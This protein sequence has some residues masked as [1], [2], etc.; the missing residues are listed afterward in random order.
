MFTHGKADR[1]LGII[2]LMILII[3]L[4]TAGDTVWLDGQER[5][6]PIK[7]QPLP[8]LGMMGAAELARH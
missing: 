3:I 7:C 8:T 6:M 2:T 5:V 1:R 4:V